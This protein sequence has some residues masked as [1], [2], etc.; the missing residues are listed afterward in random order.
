MRQPIP[1]VMSAYLSSGDIAVLPI[2]LVPL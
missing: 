1:N 2:S